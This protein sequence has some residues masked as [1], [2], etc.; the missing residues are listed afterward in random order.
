MGDEKATA[1]HAHASSGRHRPKDDEPSPNTGEKRGDAHAHS[2]KNRKGETDAAPA[3]HS[4]TLSRAQKRDAWLREA[5]RMAGSASAHVRE[6]GERA[7]L[8]PQCRQ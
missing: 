6:G 1:A 5:E 8:D 4:N 2:Q 7:C 3:P